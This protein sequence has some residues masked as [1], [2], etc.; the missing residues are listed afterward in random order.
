MY[1]KKLFIILKFLI[2][3]TILIPKSLGQI[4]Q[5]PQWFN[6]RHNPVIVLINQAVQI[7]VDWWDNQNLHKVIISENSSGNWVNHTIYSSNPT[8]TTIPRSSETSLR[9]VNIP[10]GV[11]WNQ[12][13]IFWFGSVDPTSN[14]ADVRIIDNNEYFKVYVFIFDRQ[15]WQDLTPNS[16]DLTEWDAVSLYLDLDGTVGDVPDENSYRFESSISMDNYDYE[17]REPYEVLYKGNGIS[18]TLE[19]EG[20]SY[21]LTGSGSIT[22]AW[23]GRVNDESSNSR[24]WY[25]EFMIPYSSLGFDQMPD[26]GTSWGMAIVLHDRDDEANTYIPDQVWPEAMQEN[27]PSTWGQVVFGLPVYTPPSATSEETIEI[28]DDFK[29]PDDPEGTK[30]VMDVDSGAHTTCDHHMC[31]DEQGNYIAGCTFWDVWGDTNY[32]GVAGI[33]VQ[34]VVQ[35]GDWPCSSKV[36]LSFPLDS[37]PKDMVITSAQLRMY[38]FGNA[39]PQEAK[40]TFIPIITT[41]GGWQEETLTWNNAPLARQ[42]FGGTWVKPLSTSEERKHYYWD[43]TQPLTEAY[44]AGDDLNIAL[45]SPS[46][47]MHS[48]K[49]FASKEWWR[50]SEYCP[51]LIVTYGFPV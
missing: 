41:D 21:F 23:P 45:Y 6:I 9:R 12:S 17:K 14:Y 24:C 37:I 51:T 31:R 48:G 2:L 18:W 10:R 29:K 44:L 3:C 26:N 34:N 25:V 20:E 30:F 46:T 50:D 32:A 4:E 27:T 11:S 49:Y 33:N 16:T 13:A 36:F 7:I 22:C 47:S 43:I 28:K 40:P 42:N 35:A 8:T 38:H 5:P 39:Y 1:M 19:D 15:L